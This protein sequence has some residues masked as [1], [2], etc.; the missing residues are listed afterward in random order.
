VDERPDEP[1]MLA[2][3]IDRAGVVRLGPA[4][5][6]SA[7][8]DGAALVH[9]LRG[10]PSPELELARDHALVMGRTVF[11]AELPDDHDGRALHVEPPVDGTLR[12]AVRPTGE[13]VIGA[14][15]ASEPPMPA[16]DD[17]WTA[18]AGAALRQLRRLRE[19]ADQLARVPRVT[20]RDWSRLERLIPDAERRALHPGAVV[21]LPGAVAAA[22]VERAVAREV[23]RLRRDWTARR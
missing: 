1:S 15:G 12:Y 3:M 21:G 2:Y 20:S 10:I 9:D 23:E 16:C 4:G 19:R 6:K 5:R 22:A 11:V 8:A 17:G 13:V 7:P 18:R 14:A